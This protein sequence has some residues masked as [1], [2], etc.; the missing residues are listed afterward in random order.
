MIPKLKKVIEEEVDKHIKHSKLP[1]K[2]YCPYSNREEFEIM[3]QHFNKNWV[4][5]EPNGTSGCCNNNDYN[6]W[7]YEDNVYGEKITFEQ[8]K[9]YVLNKETMEKK[10]IGYKLIKPEYE[11]AAVKITGFMGSSPGRFSNFMLTAGKQGFANDLE[12][13]GVLDLWFEPIYEEKYV[14]KKGDYITFTGGE[15]K[16]KTVKVTDVSEDIAHMYWIEHFPPI[17]IK[18]VKAK[19]E[20]NNV[21]FGCQTYSKEFVF[22]LVGLLD[23]S[24]LS[25]EHEKEIRQVD[26]YFSNF[27]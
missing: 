18:G 6:N 27:E 22:Q 2:W 21:S 20:G 19:F 14:P 3:R 13:A 8:F 7:A 17:V 25:I 23:K 11:T 9:K 10:I 24:G 4:F 5:I 26:N 1:E 16:G 12:K 15:D